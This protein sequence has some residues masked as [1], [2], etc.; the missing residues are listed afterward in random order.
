V[1]SSL[2]RRNR[3]KSWIEP[4]RI[5]DPAS[6]INARW[7]NEEL[8]LGVQ[9]KAASRAGL[10]KCFFYH[11]GISSQKFARIVLSSW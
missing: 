3:D 2:T 11:L 10:A 1:L 9:G 8:L 4:Y 7:T 6:K 5:P